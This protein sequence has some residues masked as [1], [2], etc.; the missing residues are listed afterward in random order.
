[1][2]KASLTQRDHHTPGSRLTLT[3]QDV[4]AVR[5]ETQRRA[6][7]D[8]VITAGLARSHG[9]PGGSLAGQRFVALLLLV[10]SEE[11][12]NL[13]GWQRVPAWASTEPGSQECSDAAALGT[14]PGCTAL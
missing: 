7:G 13:A 8:A 12:R 9:A 10:G 5:V 2:A 11:G 1:M 14:V 4:Y 3:K 6:G